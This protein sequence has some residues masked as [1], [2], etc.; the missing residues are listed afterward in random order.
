MSF[1]RNLAF[2]TAFHTVNTGYKVARGAQAVA[3][4]SKECGSS[5]A[6]GWRAA[7]EANRPVATPVEVEPVVPAPKRRRSK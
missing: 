3:A 4:E 5:F 6:A 7:I 2:G 1:L